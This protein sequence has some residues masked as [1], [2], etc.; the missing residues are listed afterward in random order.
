MTAR[1]YRLARWLWWKL[2][3]GARDFLRPRL[4]PPTGIRA[5]FMNRLGPA[6]VA[7]RT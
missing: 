7:T 4:F 3:V 2:P 5:A 6:A 1:F